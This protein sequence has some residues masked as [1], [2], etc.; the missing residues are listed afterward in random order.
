MIG[1]SDIVLEPNDSLALFI[2]A[3]P[4]MYPL[5]DLDVA[6]SDESVLTTDGTVLSAISEGS[7]E[8][9][10]TAKHLGKSYEASGTVTV[11]NIDYDISST[12]TATGITIARKTDTIEI[13]EEFAVQAYVLSEVT[14]EHPYP[15]GYSDDN[16]VKYSSDDPSVC[17]VKNGVLIGVAPGTA[18]ITVSDLDGHVSTT[19]DVEVVAET[20]LKY[21]DDEVLNVNAEEYDWSDAETTTL[22]IIDILSAA[23]AAGMKKVVFPNQIYTVSPAYGTINVPTNMILDFSGATIQIQE[24]AMTS[25]GY[26]MFLFQNTEYSSIVNANIYGER[27]L[28]SGTGAESCQSIYFAGHNYHSGIANCTVSNSPGFNI[29]AILKNL[30][31]VPF[32]LSALETGGIDDSGADADER[33]AFRN[34]GYMDIASIGSQFGFGNMQGYQGYLYLSARCYDIFFYDENYTFLSSMKNC[35]QY[36]MYDK[37]D[38]ARYARIVFRQG[39]APTSCEDDFGGIAHLYSVDRPQKCYIRDCV[40]ENNYSTA[41]QPNGGESWCI[42]RCTFRENG[43]R[44]PSSHI[45]WEDGRNNNKGHVLR[46]CTFEGGGTVLAVGADGL[47]IHN[48]VFDDAAFSIGG[49]VQ[50]S[51]IWLNQ[52]KGCAAT[53]SPKTDTLFAQNYGFDGA[54]YTATVGEN[55]NFAVRETCNVF[56]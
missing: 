7:A 16:L 8:I 43:F 11:R 49:E 56:E 34:N 12:R 6:S 31:R 27:N 3:R 30:V 51:R 48:N 38:N 55:V 42:E 26:H 13:G 36:Y 54:S 20:A 25:T 53:V 52:F 35:I 40:M 19:F 5:Y 2:D 28:I 21:T 37:P 46:W 47:V 50:N 44:D 15:Y 1:A 32:K 41:I 22:T 17:R 18:T 45:D 4:S 24:S 14:A 10:V 33:Y 23:S 9:D 39:S 29:G